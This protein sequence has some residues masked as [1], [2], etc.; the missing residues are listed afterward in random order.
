MN[1]FRS[2][3]LAL[4][5]PLA[6]LSAAVR[7]ADAHADEDRAKAGKVDLEVRVVYATTDHD[8]IDPA[9]EKL[10]RKMSHFKYTGFEQLDLRTLQVSGKGRETFGVVGGRKVEV[11]LLSK[12]DEKARM[13]LRMLDKGGRTIVDITFS[14]RRNGEAIVA[15]PRHKNGILV[16][17][18]K[19]SY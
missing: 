14:V 10:R 9:L 6:T 15:G 7:P 12:T 8:R 3:F 5:L 19:A 2:M 16:L 1:R 11:E 13:R 4:A 17:P 18:V